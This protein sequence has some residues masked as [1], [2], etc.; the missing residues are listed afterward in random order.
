MQQPFFTTSPRSGFLTKMA[1]KN[2]SSAHSGMPAARI[3]GT[4]SKCFGNNT[5]EAFKTD[6]SVCS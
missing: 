1:V 5:D 4:A 2:I 3:A 6:Q